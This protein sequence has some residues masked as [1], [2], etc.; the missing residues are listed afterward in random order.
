MTGIA[1][2]ASDDRLAV[3]LA[4]GRNVRDAADDLGLSESTAFRR[5]RDP[6][7]VRQLAEARAELWDS[8]LGL[9]ADASSEAV[10]T[11]RELLDSELD[12]VRLAA[13]KTILD[14]GT[15]LRESCD[16]HSRLLILEDRA[17]A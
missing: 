3:L 1:R 12:S 7:F 5:L 15:K 16:F 4:S 8:S 9:L 13:A 11:L 6:R 17:D 10:N 14:L 2:S